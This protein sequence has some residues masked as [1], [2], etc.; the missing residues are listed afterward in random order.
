MSQLKCNNYLIVGI[1]LV[2]LSEWTIH[3]QIRVSLGVLSIL[4]NEVPHQLGP[5]LAGPDVDREE[6]LVR[7]WERWRC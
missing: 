1:V 3:V 4:N 7:G 6:V 2:S 5:S